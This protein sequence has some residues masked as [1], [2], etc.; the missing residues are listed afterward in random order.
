[1]KLKVAGLSFDLLAKGLFR[2]AIEEGFLE[3]TKVKKVADTHDEDEVS[4]E[5]RSDEPIVLLRQA[6]FRECGTKKFT[7]ADGRPANLVVAERGQ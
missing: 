3:G 2:P 6:G 4:G 5:R 7:G 1:M